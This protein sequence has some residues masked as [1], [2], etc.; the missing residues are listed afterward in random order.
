MK[1]P[2]LKYLFEQLDSIKRDLVD[3]IEKTYPDFPSFEDKYNLIKEGKVVLRPVAELNRYT[4][5]VEAYDFSAYPKTSRADI[6]QHKQ[7]ALRL[8]IQDIKNSVVFD[9]ETA[10]HTLIWDARTISIEDL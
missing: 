1:A 9:G 8:R 6:R 7:E 4:D 10:A 5:L 3:K 2:Q